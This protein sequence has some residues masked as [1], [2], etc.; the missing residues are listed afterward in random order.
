MIKLVA[1]TASATAAGSTTTAAH[2]PSLAAASSSPPDTRFDAQHA[3]EAARQERR[4]VQ[5][6]TAKKPPSSSTAQQDAVAPA[7][8]VD[9]SAQQQPLVPAAPSAPRMP[10]VC[11]AQ[12]I[13]TSKLRPSV[14][15]KP[16]GRLAYQAWAR[17]QA[18]LLTAASVPS[19]AQAAPASSDDEDAAE[20][21]SDGEEATSERRK[22]PHST[23]KYTKETLL[24]IK[25]RIEATQRLWCPTTKQ[26]IIANTVKLETLGMAAQW[27]QDHP[28]GGNSTALGGMPSGMC[29]VRCPNCLQFA[30]FVLVP[31]AHHALL[32]EIHAENLESLALLSEH[33]KHKPGKKKKLPSKDKE[34]A[35]TESTST[36]HEDFASKRSIQYW[37]GFADLH[38]LSWGAFPIAT[39]RAI[40]GANIVAATAI[41]TTPSTGSNG[42]FCDSNAPVSQPMPTQERVFHEGLDASHC[43]ELAESGRQHC[44]DC[45]C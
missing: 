33:M 18:R 9:D 25:S 24:A 21:A 38:G 16:R 35:I 15:M 28:T 29:A 37:L 26:C 43:C 13:D 8:L 31:P 40:P 19:T 45:G 1:S 7:E 5:Q 20:D 41:S 27:L 23:R 3:H 10:T 34:C 44:P 11:L 17:Q 39:A 32:P 36:W 42:L 6:A 4:A 22:I 12:V 30:V 2:T 14:H